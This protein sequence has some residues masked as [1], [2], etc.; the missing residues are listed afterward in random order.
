MVAV[1]YFRPFLLAVLICAFVLA[2]ADSSIPAFAQSGAG[3]QAASYALSGS[4]VNSVTGDPIR[5]ALVQVGDRMQLTDSQGRF[6]ISDLPGGRYSVSAQKPGFFFGSRLDSV[7]L[8]MFTLN[9]DLAGIVVKLVPEGIIF[10]RITDENG[11]PVEG[12]FVRVRDWRIV[13]GRRRQEFVGGQSTDEDGRFRL[14]GLMP[15]TYYAVASAATE[16]AAFAPASFPREQGYGA[17]YFPGVTQFTAATPIKLAAGQKAQADFALS[18]HPTFQITGAISGYSDGK[19]NSVQLTDPAG[20]ESSLPVRFDPATGT[21]V[22]KEVP[23]GSYRLEAAAADRQGHSLFGE[24]ALNVAA[25][26]SG[27]MVTVAAGISL[28]VIVQTEFGGSPPGDHRTPV[29]VHL[30]PAG[31]SGQNFFRTEVWSRPEGDKASGGL[32][33]PE[34]QPGKYYAE[35]NPNGNWYVQSAASGSTDL[36]AEPLMV[37]SG[38]APIQ[39][40]LRD[41]G[42][43]LTS[44]VR[45]QGVATPAAALVVMQDEPLRIPWVATANSQGEFH[46]DNLPPGEYVVL[47]FDNLGDLEYANRDALRDYFSKGTHVTL[48]SK[49]AKTINVELIRR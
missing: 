38:V 1:R 4:V 5:R 39:I 17:T 35:F 13:D 25:N 9:R 22:A 24:A 32:V 21:F 44:D 19:L 11:D 31:I 18:P 47:A 49:D 36:F 7:G 26:M 14:F 42:A 48:G 46:L 29:A 12:A 16:R 15:G 3:S 28:P 37:S 23:A 41:D 43:T 20:G 2:A 30:L 34:V 10:G 33:V 6:A 45:S 40:L 27:I 8:S